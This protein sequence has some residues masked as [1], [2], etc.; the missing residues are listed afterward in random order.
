MDYLYCEFNCFVHRWCHNKLAVSNCSCEKLH[1]HKTAACE[2][3]CLSCVILLSVV[4]IA[5]F[6]SCA[7]H[8][9]QP[10]GHTY[11]NSCCSDCC[12]KIMSKSEKR[13]ILM[14]N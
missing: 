13:K 2:F 8:C 9:S 1:Q 14:L 5:A 4:K 7:L 3:Q 10:L 12:N 11:L 6:L